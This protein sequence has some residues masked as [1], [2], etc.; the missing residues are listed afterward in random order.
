MFKYNDYGKS[1]QQEAPEFWRRAVHF[2]RTGENPP[3]QPYQVEIHPL[4]RRTHICH[5]RCADCHGRFLQRGEG[6]DSNNYAILLRDLKALQ[7]PSIVLSG[8]Y[9]DPTMNDAMLWGILDNLRGTWPVKLHTF[10]INLN[11]LLRR[12]I[13][14]TALA[15]PEGGSYLTISKLTV[16][17]EVYQALCHPMQ[18]PELVLQEEEENLKALFRETESLPEKKLNVRINCRLTKIN[19]HREQ[20]VAL[21]AWVKAYS[22]LVSVRFTTDYFPTLAP[23]DY[24]DYF[25]RELFVGAAEA[26]GMF[27]DALEKSY[28]P[29]DRAS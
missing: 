29:R 19:S 5:L 12:K 24:R 1:F 2:A 14:E 18:N 21:L 3:D 10:G 15:A 13:I 26:E 20:L 17:P 7:V 27:Q 9:S 8:A 23:E 11:P 6:L 4:S 25:Y 16:D 28:F 22:P